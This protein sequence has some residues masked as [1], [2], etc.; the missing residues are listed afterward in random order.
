MYAP[1]ELTPRILPWIKKC[2]DVRE[3]FQ[4]FKGQYKGE[5]FESVVPPPNMF[6]DAISCKQFSKFISQYHFR[7]E[8]YSK[9]ESETKQEVATIEREFKI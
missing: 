7:S 9:V 3:F 4:S 8:V 1:Y 2:V 6:P 5:S